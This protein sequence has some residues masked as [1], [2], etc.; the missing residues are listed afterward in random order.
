MGLERNIP[1]EIRE[2]LGNTLQRH[3]FMCM[4]CG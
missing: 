1:A 2:L 4:K 3:V